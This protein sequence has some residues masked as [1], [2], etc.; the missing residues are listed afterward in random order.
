MLRR[1]NAAWSVVALAPLGFYLL[2]LAP[3][4]SFCAVPF[5]FAVQSHFNGFCATILSLIAPFS[6]VPVLCLALFA[7]VIAY[8]FFFTPDRLRAAFYAAGA[9]FLMSTTAHPW[10]LLLATIFVPFYPSLPWIM[11][12]LTVGFAALVNIAYVET[13]VWKESGLLWTAEYVPFALAALW[14][15]ISRTSFAAVRFEKPS[16]LSIVIPTI[17]EREN[18]LACIDAIAPCKELS[19][20]IV[21]ADGGSTDGTLE[22]L[23][24]RPAVRV[25]GAHRGRGIQIGRGIAAS[26]GDVILVLHADSRP[27]K[28]LI[29]SLAHALGKS[30]HIAGGA[31][32][33]RYRSNRKRYV[34]TS[35][36]NNCRTLLTGISFGDQ[37]QFFRTAAIGRGFPLLKIMEDVELSFLMMESGSVAFLKCCVSNS[38]RKW[39]RD[40]YIRNC[41]TV[42]WLTLRYVVLRGFGL[43]PADCE[44]YYV[45]YYQ[46]RLGS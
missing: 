23:A 42:V 43:H 35:W 14:A 7:A 12:H 11:L 21:V 40:G 30:P 38:V 1:N 27:D 5:Q 32:R 29:P 33:A 37:A 18:I 31:F 8:L 34:L 44:E 25:V 4:V 13:G 19:H 41:A 22:A 16:F 26:Q 17:N 10:Y 6:R 9:F 46:Q 24:H 36:L 2:Y 39:E 3:G 15:F 20:E 45:R 28:S